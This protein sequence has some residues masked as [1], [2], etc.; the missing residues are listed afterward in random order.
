M[1]SKASRPNP[2]FIKFLT[3]TEESDHL[4]SEGAEIKKKRSPIRQPDKNKSQSLLPM[5]IKFVV[6]LLIA[7]LVLVGHFYC[8]LFMIWSASYVYTETL[9]LSRVLR[10]DQEIAF[11][12]VDWYWYAVCF[13][14]CIPY[15]FNRNKI[16]TIESKTIQIFLY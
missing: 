3:E 11:H 10:K 16:Y 12:W 15:A 4:T 13:Y 9:T 5:I 6:W 14:V 1:S 2:K 7:Q 8:A